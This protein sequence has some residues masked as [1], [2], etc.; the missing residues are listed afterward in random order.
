MPR[1][2]PLAVGTE[3]T[4]RWTYQV[5]RLVGG[6]GMA[7]VYQI[8]RLNGSTTSLWALKEL[9]PQTE[10][11]DTQAHARQ[12]F[13]QEA[14]ILSQLDHPNLPQV[15]DF[16]EDAGRAYLVMEFI[17]G[18]SLEKRLEQTRSPLMERQ[19][20][21]WAVQVCEVLDYL[22][23]R[24]PPVIFRDL[25]PSNV[26]VNNA[27]VVKLV[28]FGIA[29]TYKEHKLQ[30]TI[31]LGSENYAA[32][33]QW[34][35]AQTD[36]RSDIYGLGSTMYHLLANMPPSPAFLPTEPTSLDQLSGAISKETVQI[37]TKAMARDREERYASAAEM[38][39]AL[40]A[41]LPGYVSPLQPKAVPQTTTTTPPSLQ[42]PQARPA[43][44]TQI[45]PRT[46]TPPQQTRQPAT[47]ATQTQ[48][49]PVV[50]RKVR[51]VKVCPRCKHRSELNARFCVRCGY[52]FVG[53][54][55]AVLRVIEPVRAA[56]EMPVA[57]SPM[58]FGR[59]RPEEGYRPDFDM[60][61][62][63][64]EGYISRR[65]GQIIKARNGYFITDLGSSNGTYVN[66]RLLPPNKPRLL[67]NGDE[68]SIGEVVLQ[69]LLR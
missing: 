5:K 51:R 52:A 56:W 21:Q 57:K 13:D 37:V 8:E 11:P 69:F 59:A 40:L 61:F 35:Q 16:F 38:R 9:R 47:A 2:K 10:D 4:G 41:C 1:E 23:S 17:W 34:G 62:Y 46:Q 64:P 43:T 32:P 31:A 53:V 33:E 39:D 60:S 45:R 44:E 50:R 66:D 49:K 65:H 18:E 42:Q 7:W 68:I 63:D 29:R 15:I 54:R 27:G 12:L 3:L 36:P 26:M 14:S 25:K 30:D 28:D 20:L 22:H 58:L 48:L 24:Q 67:R 19:V 6:G 55:P